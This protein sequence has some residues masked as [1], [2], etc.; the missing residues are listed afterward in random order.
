MLGSCALKTLQQGQKPNT[1]E[2][3]QDETILP[4][5]CLLLLSEV[6]KK[7][8]W[9]DRY[10][11]TETTRRKRT[12]TNSAYFEKPACISACWGMGDLW[13]EKEED[14]QHPCHCSSPCPWLV[15]WPAKHLHIFGF[16]FQS[17]AFSAHCYIFFFPT[18]ASV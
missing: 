4:P 6:G 5:Q 13:G 7:R 18:A 15:L 2:D 14:M 9:I 12:G 16:T 10:F 11:K 3:N 17:R 1:P 8:A